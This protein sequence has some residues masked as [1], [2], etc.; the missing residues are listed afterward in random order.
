MLTQIKM[1]SLRRAAARSM[2]RIDWIHVLSLAA[3]LGLT[4]GAI[5][6]LLAT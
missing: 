3:T 6:I 1:D 4:G 5:C 2:E